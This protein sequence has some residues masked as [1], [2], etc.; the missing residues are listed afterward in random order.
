MD[1]NANQR[2]VSPVS[3]HGGNRVSPVDSERRRVSPQ[4]ERERRNSSVSVRRDDGVRD[5][6]VHRREERRTYHDNEGEPYHRGERLDRRNVREDRDVGGHDRHHY[7][8]EE[9]F[10]RGSVHV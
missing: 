7:S 4:S 3:N 1:M 8:S 2:R 9:E 6:H 5:N 10:D